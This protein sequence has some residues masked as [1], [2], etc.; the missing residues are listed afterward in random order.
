MTRRF[1][2]TAVFLEIGMILKSSFDRLIKQHKPPIN[3]VV[4]LNKIVLIPSST[5]THFKKNTG[6]ALEQVS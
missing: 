6:E 3:W 5:I 4:K 2:R 1:L